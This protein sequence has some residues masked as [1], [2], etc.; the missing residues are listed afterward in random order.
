[1]IRI[2]QLSLIIA[3]VQYEGSRVLGDTC[4]CPSSLGTS[5]AGFSSVSFSKLDD[6]ED[7]VNPGRGM[8]MMVEA[9]TSKFSPLKSDALNSSYNIVLRLYYLDT[10]IT[11][12]LDSDFLSKVRADLAM[13]QSRGWTVILRF[14]YTRTCSTHDASLSQMLQHIQYL[15]RHNVFRDYGGVI[16]AIQAGFIGKWGEWHYWDE[17]GNCPNKDFGSPSGCSSTFDLTPDQWSARKQILQA[18]LDA[19]PKS[20]DIQVRIPAYKYHEFGKTATTLADDQAETDASR[21]SYHNDA[22][23]SGPGNQGT[24]PCDGDATFMADDSTYTVVTGETNDP[25]HTSYYECSKAKADL[26]KFHYSTVHASYEPQVISYWQ[27]HGCFNEIAARLGYRLYLTNAILPDSAQS[28]GQFCYK[29][30]LHNNGYAAPYKPLEARIVLQNTGDG[31]Q[32]NLNIP[33]VDVRTWQPGKDIHLSGSITI[34]SNL[35]GNFKTYLVLAHE[36]MRTNSKYYVLLANK[37]GVRH[38]SSRMNDLQHTVSISAGTCSGTSGSGTSSSTCHS[39]H[40][41]DGSF[42]NSAHGWKLYSHGF[43]VQSD[44]HAEDGRKIIH[45]TNGGALQTIDFSRAPVYEFR[46]SGYSR[47]NSAAHVSDPTDYSIYCD[48]VHTDGKETYGQTSNFDSSSTPNVWHFKELHVHTSKLIREATCYAMFRNSQGYAEFDHFK[49]NTCSG[50]S[51]AYQTLD[52][53]FEVGDG[54][55]NYHDG[56]TR[57]HSHSSAE[58]GNYY[59]TVTNGGASQYIDFDSGTVTRFTLSGYSRA[60]SVSGISGSDYSIY[61]DLTHPGHTNTWGE[62]ANFDPTKS[63]W[64]KAVLQV[65][66]QKVISGARCYAMFRNG[67][68][69]ADFDNFQLEFCA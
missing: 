50:E 43:T 60:H 32:H 5:S 30:T 46:L 16:A 49:L 26:A 54:W 39:L 65:V 45:I 55:E 4:S 40:L 62:H 23:L 44:N 19:S 57:T 25:S 64:H 22:L 1:M 11:G 15:D 36:T 34:P 17:N 61:C 8:Y 38:T 69:K 56:F 13:A 63:S 18:L 20:V 31:S 12:D 67:H 24:F 29:I 66:S 2:L 7:V 27:R 21:I 6:S 41:S 59:I 53:S 68:G 58:S 47:H 28:S 35:H 48:L 51:C 9:F 42:E 37:N 3:L 14:A 10:Y 52:G 33:N